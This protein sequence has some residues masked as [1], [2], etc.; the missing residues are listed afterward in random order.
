M[1]SLHAEIPGNF[2]FHRSHHEIQQLRNPLRRCKPI[3]EVCTDQIN[4]EIH[5]IDILGG[6]KLDCRY[7]NK[8]C[9]GFSLMFLL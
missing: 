5:Q 2:V 4:I 3:L 8:G 9:R 6:L 7:L 1:H